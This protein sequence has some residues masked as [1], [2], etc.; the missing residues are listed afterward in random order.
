MYGVFLC[1]GL[2]RFYKKQYLHAAHD[3]RGTTLFAVVALYPFIYFNYPLQASIG[4]TA[5]L[6][7]IIGLSET[8]VMSLIKK[9]LLKRDP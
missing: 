3:L 2:A 7:T 1:F 4:I 9:L 8:S 6:M 5:T